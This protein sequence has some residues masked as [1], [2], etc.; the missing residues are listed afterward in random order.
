MIDR[1]GKVQLHRP[2]HAVSH[3]LNFE[4]FY[5]NPRL[6]LDAEVMADLY[7]CNERSSEDEE[8]V[9]RILNELSTYKREESFF[10]LKLAIRQRSTSAPLQHFDTCDII[11]LIL[12]DD[13][14]GSNEWLVEEMGGDD[15]DVEDDLYQ[16][17][18]DP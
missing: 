8:M 3:F 4:F 13:I 7:S 11:D 1:I 10:G 18:Y 9:D 15:E 16:S 6:D 17:G 2:L 14:D 5:K 12:V